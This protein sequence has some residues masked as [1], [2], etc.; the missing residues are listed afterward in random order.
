MAVKITWTPQAE[1]GFDDII[2]YIRKHWTEREVFSFINEVR[3]FLSLLK[4]NPRLLQS[5]PSK[6]DLY[7]GPINRLTILTYRFNR[8]TNEIELLN[9][10][11]A[12]QRPFEH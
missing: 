9:I 3:D 11:S 10:R 6:K 2:V 5:S 12:R 4:N 7:R 1:Q 8:R